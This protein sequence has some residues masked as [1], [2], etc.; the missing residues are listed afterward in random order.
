LGGS[1]VSEKIIFFS[2]TGTY[3]RFSTSVTRSTRASNAM[4]ALA[5]NLIDALSLG[6]LFALI[7]IGVAILYTVMGLMNFAQGE[8]IMVPAYVLYALVGVP[9]GLAVVAAVLSGIVLAL[10]ADRVAFRPVRGADL[11]TQLVTS[12]AVATILEN[13]V[14]SAV[15]ARAQSVATPT[16][17]AQNTQIG[18]LNVPNL[19]WITL[20]IS[21]VVLVGLGALLYRT[22]TG[23]Q[24]R[25]AAENFEMARL[26]GVRADRV[27]AVAF[28]ISGGLG[29]LVGVILVMQTGQVSPTMGLTPVLVG[30]V[31]VVIGGFGRLSGALLGGLVLGALSSLLGAYLP[32][33]LLPFRDAIVF[34][35]PIAI[36]LVRPAGLLGAVHGEARV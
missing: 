19:E 14:S 1:R 12:L 9:F 5:Q 8:F 16:L 21:L 17:V 31:A 11:A 3:R 25:A 20:G 13:L 24:M 4:T 36:L 33:G 34:T 2:G 23:L 10:L 6:S 26:V 18:S 15:A 30:F 28:A 35:V 32:A 27:I 29:A 7:A 22:T